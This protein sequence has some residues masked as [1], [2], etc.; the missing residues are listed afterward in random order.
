M[1]Y[2]FKNSGQF[3]WDLNVM[4]SMVHRAPI[5]E[6]RAY[7]YLNKGNKHH[8]TC[9]C[10]WVIS[11]TVFTGPSIVTPFYIFI[12]ERKEKVAW[13]A[14]ICS[15]HQTWDA[16]CKIKQL[17]KSIFSN[18]HVLDDMDSYIFIEIIYISTTVWSLIRDYFSLAV[19][20]S[21]WWFWR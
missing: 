10:H 7:I 15:K 20:Y 5:S 14:G 8:F 16:W 13:F 19:I 17:L 12:M 9:N 2:C 21:H 6:F 4:N 3:C 18:L 11:Y 1:K